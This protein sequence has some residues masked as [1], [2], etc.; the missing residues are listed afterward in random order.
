MA[1]HLQDRW[2]W[3]GVGVFTF[4]AIKAVSAGLHHTI[5]LT[6][7]HNPPPSKPSIPRPPGDQIDTIKAG[8][9][10]VLA[11]SDNVDIRKA[12]TR[13]LCERFFA[14]K[15]LHRLLLRDLRSDNDA[16]KRRAQLAVR[17]LDDNGLLTR[18]PGHLHRNYALRPWERDIEG[19]LL[20][21]SARRL[22]GAR[23]HEESNEERDLR[24]RRRE[25]VVIN[26]GDRPVSEGDVYMRDVRGEM[27]QEEVV[28]GLQ[29]LTE[30]FEDFEAML[31]GGIA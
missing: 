7:V 22:V 14:D 3:L 5:H 23:M 1:T 17:L 12:A 2:L 29:M 4:V 13:I 26:E 30:A 16:T 28:Q 11:T 20:S 8:A 31:N 9:L 10:D 21:L 25:A 18:L 6:Q 15:K 19:P 27:T 24:R